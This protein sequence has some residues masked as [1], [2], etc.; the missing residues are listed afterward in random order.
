[1]NNRNNHKINN[2]SN[3]RNLVRYDKLLLDYVYNNVINDKCNGGKKG[4]K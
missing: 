1:M 3:T 4:K 2:N